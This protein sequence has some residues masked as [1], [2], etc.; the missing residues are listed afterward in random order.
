MMEGTAMT[1]SE[2]EAPSGSA[3]LGASISP[4]IDADALAA[5][6]AALGEQISRDYAGRQPLLVV[7]MHG[8]LIF[9]ADLMRRIRC[10][11]DLACVAISSYPQGTERLLQPRF[12]NGVDVDVRGRD[13][14]VV[15]DIV[16]TGRTISA[17][18]SHLQGLS[19]AS[20][21]VATC[22]DKPSQ[23]KVEVPLRYVGFEV[24]SVFVVGYGLDYGGRYRNL[25][26]VAD[27]TAAGVE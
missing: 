16:D 17:L 14:I 10:H 19:P 18:L 23:R 5:R 25:P 8:A 9:A 26:Y 15:E 20:V 2:V 11:I 13:V 6:V 22:L 27:L 1:A 21:A 3:G 24:P 12:L 4:L 7:V